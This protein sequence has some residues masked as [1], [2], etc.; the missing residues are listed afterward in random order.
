MRAPPALIG[1]QP[2]A[3]SEDAGTDA[4][5]LTAAEVEQL[6]ADFVTAASRAELAGFDGVELHCAH[7][8]VLAQFLSPEANRREDG[9]G[10]SLDGRARVVFDILRGIRARCRSGFVVGVRISPERFGLRLPEMISLAATLMSSGLIDFLDLSLWD[11]FKEPMDESFRGRSL[12]AC[13]SELDRGGVRLG[14]AGKIMGG[15]DAT[16]ALADGLDFIIVGRGAILHHDF[17]QRVR[18]DPAFHAVGLPV[19]P[20]YLSAEG[21]SPPFID[22]MGNWQG[23]VAG[24]AAP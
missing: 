11:V 16:R 9:Y 10:G 14:G 15:P 17:P 24:E 5:A 12:L 19:T 23:F 21:L 3:P 22:Y 7:G 4:R 1:G 2:V 18:T 13:F 8:Y 20:D 6:V